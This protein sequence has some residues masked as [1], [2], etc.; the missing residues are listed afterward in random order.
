MAGI[1]PSIS[2]RHQPTYA[3]MRVVNLDINKYEYYFLQ[4][5][6]MWQ[7]TSI[8]GNDVGTLLASG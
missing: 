8:N 1:V 3:A 7:L 6:T 2:D 5:D 4:V